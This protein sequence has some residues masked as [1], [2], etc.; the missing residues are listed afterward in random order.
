VEGKKLVVVHVV[1]G[2]AAGGE[3]LGCML[4]TSRDAR[5]LSTVYELAAL[6]RPSQLCRRDCMEAKL[7]LTKF[8]NWLVQQVTNKAVNRGRMLKVY[9]GS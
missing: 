8:D 9:D 3:V 2:V 4:Y 5:Y 1:V 7:N 6:G